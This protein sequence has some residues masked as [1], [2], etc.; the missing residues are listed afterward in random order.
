MAKVSYD[1]ELLEL[2]DFPHGDTFLPD[3]IEVFDEANDPVDLTA[4]EATLRLED[5]DGTEVVTLTELSGITLGNGF[6]QF[7]TETTT[8]PYYVVGDLQMI[9][10]GGNTE[11][12]VRVVVKLKKTISLP[13]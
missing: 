2:C 3:Q 8:W 11:T 1:P 6:L 12:W 10:P 13:V 9:P 4:Y 7:S 5:R